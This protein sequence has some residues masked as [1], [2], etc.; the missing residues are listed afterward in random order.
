MGQRHQV[1]VVVK[2]NGKY[3]CVA[4]VHNQW[5]YGR[6]ALMGCHRAIQT[7]K[8]SKVL[9]ENVVEQAT[10]QGLKWLSMLVAVRQMFNECYPI[11]IPQDPFQEDNN[12]GITVIDITDVDNPAVCFNSLYHYDCPRGTN[13]DPEEYMKLYEDE[14]VERTR[15]VLDDVKDY[16]LIDISVLKEVWPN[17]YWNMASSL[18]KG[19]DDASNLEVVSAPVESLLEK[20]V[21]KMTESKENSLLE[22]PEDLKEMAMR[23]VL[24]GKVPVHTLARVIPTDLIA[25]NLSRCKWDKSYI[26]LT[27]DGI[28][29]ASRLE[30]LNVTGWKCLDDETLARIGSSC[31]WMKM[32]VVFGCDRINGSCFV[33]LEKTCPL[34]QYLYTDLRNMLTPRSTLIWTGHEMRWHFGVPLLQQASRFMQASE[35]YPHAKDYFFRN[36]LLSTEESC[37]FYEWK[38]YR[39]A[40]IESFPFIVLFFQR[41]DLYLILKKEDDPPTEELGCQTVTLKSG[42][43]LKLSI[44]E[45]LKLCYPQRSEHPGDLNEYLI[46]M[47]K[48]QSEELSVLLPQKLISSESALKQNLPSFLL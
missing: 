6:L 4:A 34:L 45:Y 19:K 43:Y 14:Y 28:S 5:S 36:E 1:Y 26:K 40:N 21:V 29:Q 9:V 8:V 2:R 33:S 25:L 48:S 10:E 42:K 44:E 47:V 39:E 41:K 27:A 16:P 17:G 3:K 7:I 20:T 38:R 12:D 13:L 46:A 15:K 35:D 37:V 24:T 22:F 11:D 31:R 23:M 30:I 32:L 18:K